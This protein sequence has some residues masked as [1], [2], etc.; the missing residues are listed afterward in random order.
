MAVNV[1]I[2]KVA[3]KTHFKKIHFLSLWVIY[4]KEI[5]R[6]GHKDLS[7]GMSILVLNV[8]EQNWKQSLCP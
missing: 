2:A 5:I 6:D 3:S 4:P 1:T 7:P 8:I